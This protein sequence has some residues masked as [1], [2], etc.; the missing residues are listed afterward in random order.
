MINGGIVGGYYNVGGKNPIVY[1]YGKNQTQRVGQ[2][3]SPSGQGSSRAAEFKTTADEVLDSGK[4]DLLTISNAG[5]ES[6]I[7]MTQGKADNTVIQFPAGR[8]NLLFQGYSDSQYQI[9]FRVELKQIQDG[10]DDTLIT[11]TTGYTA[12]ASPAT[13][14]Y[15]LI[16]TDFIVTGTEKFYFLFPIAGNNNRS[17]FLRIEK[18]A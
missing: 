8:Y 16:W 13:T 3:Y 4:A 6:T 17:H 7:D 14:A 10:T 15:Q 5:D 2:N 11:Q 18:V 12:A 9:G 1:Y